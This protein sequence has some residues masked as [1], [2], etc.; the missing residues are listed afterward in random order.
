MKRK[1][2][3]ADFTNSLAKKDSNVISAPPA[4]VG[5]PSLPT[6]EVQTDS[7]T[8]PPKATPEVANKGKKL[9]SGFQRIT[10]SLTEADLKLADDKRFS[11]GQ[12]HRVLLDRSKLLKVALRA[13]DPD[14]PQIQ[15]WIADVVDADLR[16]SKTK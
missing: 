16:K 15:K 7:E 11:I 1:D 13:L 6:K 4:A 2:I 3:L 10:V 5:V 14:H 12:K 9:K 8:I